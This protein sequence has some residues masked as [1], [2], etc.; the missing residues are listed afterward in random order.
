MAI[1]EKERQTVEHI[2]KCNECDSRNLERDEARGELICNDCGLVL[3]NNEIDMGQEWRVFTPEQGD[4]LART[5]APSTYLLHDKGLSTTIDWMNRDYS[6]KRISSSK[7]SQYHRMRKWQQRARTKNSFDRNLSQALPEIAR[8]SE[9]LGFAKGLVEEASLV[10]RK[11][12]EKNLARGRSIDALVAA[13]IYLVCN[14]NKLGRTLDEVCSATR[15]GRKELTKCYKIVKQSLGVRMEVNHPRDFVPSFISKLGLPSE[16]QSLTLDILAKA[17]QREL[18]Y[19]RSPTGVAAA[20]IYIAANI[21]GRSRTQREIAD[22]SSVTEV[23][24]RNRYK[25]LAKAL[26]IKV[27]N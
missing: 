3:E 19:G 1:D 6:G 9:N 5:G 22:V 13:S 7:R 26:D 12:L 17:E 2:V 16:V 11:S 14:R 21:A 25:E 10:Y 27:E 24:I 20:A 18:T 8:I 15:V 23:T 4:S